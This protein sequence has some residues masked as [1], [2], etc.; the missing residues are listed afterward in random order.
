MIEGTPQSQNLSEAQ[1]A[2][3]ATALQP[4]WNKLF[5]DMQTR[6]ATPE[7]IAE[8]RVLGAAFGTDKMNDRQIM[9]L[10]PLALAAEF[11]PLKDPKMADAMKRSIVARGIDDATADS[12][13]KDFTQLNDMN[14]G[15]NFGALG[16]YLAAL[17]NEEE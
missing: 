5:L 14:I 8:V 17:E 15:S 6:V 16:K 4:V 9:A 11:N 13:V 2:S 7:I 10:V 3:L 12:I 1:I